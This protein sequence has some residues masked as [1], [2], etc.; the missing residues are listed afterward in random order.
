MLNRIPVCKKVDLMS[1]SYLGGKKV[2]LLKNR[3]GRRKILEG[4]GKLKVLIV[5]MI[6]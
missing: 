6:S 3:G 2:N 5:V 1:C 4:M